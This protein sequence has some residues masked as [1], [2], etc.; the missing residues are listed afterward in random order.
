MKT[1]F[2]PTTINGLRLANRL[3]R[4]ATWEGL[5][6]PDGGVNDRLVEI[7]RELADG[8]VG[9]IITGYIAVRA[10]GRQAATQL[11]S[12]SD[13]FIPGL[14]RIAETVH[15]HGGKVVA[16]IV[17]CGLLL[18]VAAADPRARS[19]APVGLGRPPPRGLRVVQRLLR[20]GATRRGHPVR[21]ARRVM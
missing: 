12:D 4:S 9:L 5:G 8:G 19:A 14:A 16:Q 15:H 20:P 13:D 1:I 21:S 7:Y 10:D 6:D 3:V 11:L 18:H 17:H 2:E